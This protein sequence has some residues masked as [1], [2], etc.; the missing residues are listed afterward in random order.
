VP[1][2]EAALWGAI[3][4]RGGFAVEFRFRAKD[5]SWRWILARGKVVES[6]PDGKALRMAGSHTDIGERKRAEETLHKYER[7]VAC[8]QDLMALIGRGYVYEAVNDSILAIYGLPREQVVGRTISEVRGEDVFERSIRPWID[9]ALAGEAVRYQMALE[10]GSS[11]KRILDINYVPSADEHGRVD[12]VVLNA[13]DITETRKLE[14]QLI[15]SQKIESLGTLARGIAHDFNNILGALIGYAELALLELPAGHAACEHLD[16]VLA[17][18]KRARDLVKQILAFGRQGEEGR[19]PIQLEHT[20]R[21]VTQFLRASLPVTIEIRQQIEPGL[22][23]VLADPVQI[24]QVVMN[25][26]T[27]AGHAMQEGGGVLEI[28]LAQLGAFPESALRPPGLKPGPY[29][30]LT[31]RDSG[32]GMDPATLEKI[33]DPYFTTKE[34]GVGTGLGLSMVHG[35]VQSHGGQITVESAPGQ[36]A[37]FDVYFPAV[38]RQA[39]QAASA[40]PELPRGSERILLVDDEAFLADMGRQILTRLGYRVEARTSSVDALEFF[41]A[42]PEEFDLVITDMT[43]PHLTGDRLAMEIQHIR[44]GTPVLLCTGYSEERQREAFKAM[45]IRGV[46][47]KPVLM[48]QMAVAV[49][50]ALDK[51]ESGGDEAEPGGG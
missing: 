10:F 45:G 33:F 42:Q 48:A 47:M 7:I 22:D 25:L 13:R 20:I 31:V 2:T 18:G 32:H 16:L 11:G 44:P 14:E 34:K 12:G 39:R 28:R 38:G 37:Q 6:D 43:M 1:R 8:S 29:L 49:R 36:G 35:I 51:R 41:R 26:C 19:K 24:H 17:A 40:S 21:E 15:Q 5:G 46:I 23:D 3:E 9:M 4:A 30:R 50:E 27:N